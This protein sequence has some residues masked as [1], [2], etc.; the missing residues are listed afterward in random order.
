MPAG[1]GEGC[2]NE[3][4][5]TRDAPERLRVSQGAVRGSGRL[6]AIAILWRQLGSVECAV[7]AQVAGAMASITVLNRSVRRRKRGSPMPGYAVVS[8]SDRNFLDSGYIRYRH[9][10]FRPSPPRPVE[11]PAAFLAPNSPFAEGH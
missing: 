9:H 8:R 11:C 7:R 4:D 10:P 2:S 1:S 3:V 5:P 6:Y